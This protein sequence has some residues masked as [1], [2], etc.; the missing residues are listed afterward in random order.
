MVGYRINW[1]FREKFFFVK[2]NFYFK[3]FC[4]FEEISFFFVENNFIVFF[5]M[6]KFLIFLI[7]IIENVIFCGKEKYMWESKLFLE[8]IKSLNDYIVD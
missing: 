5:N 1:L 4:F 6:I 8:I 3:K 2:K 7:S